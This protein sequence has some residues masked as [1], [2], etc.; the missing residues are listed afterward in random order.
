MLRNGSSLCKMLAFAVLVTSLALTVGS[1]V[2]SAQSFR[3]TYFSNA[4]QALDGKVRLVN[5]GS[6]ATTNAVRRATAR[7]CTAR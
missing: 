6:A 7:R 5:G 2:A 3:Y 4:R 1:G